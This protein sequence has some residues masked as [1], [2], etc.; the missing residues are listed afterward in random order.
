V[1]YSRM[2]KKLQSKAEK[3]IN[4]FYAANFAISTAFAIL[5]FFILTISLP[6]WGVVSLAASA[7]LLAFAF[8][9]SIAPPTVPNQVENNLLRAGF[10]PYNNKFNR[11]WQREDVNFELA[12]FHDSVSPTD[13]PKCY[14]STFSRLK[15]SVQ[16]NGTTAD[17]SYEDGPWWDWALE[18]T[19]ALAESRQQEIQRDQ[20]AVKEAILSKG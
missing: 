9:L 6:G 18:Y 4:D 12:Y 2:S 10:H 14:P 11:T 13:T 8:G 7:G 1:A 3:A 16:I 19:A 15:L 17:V 20:A 5:L